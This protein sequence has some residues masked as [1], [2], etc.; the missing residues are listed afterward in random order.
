MQ[1]QTQNLFQE[2]ELKNKLLSS[3]DQE[4]VDL[5]AKFDAFSEYLKKNNSSLVDQINK[6]HQQ[7]T[8]RLEASITD[9]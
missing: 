7:E 1:L 4:K 2:C 5:L 8:E 9:L 3:V 6:R